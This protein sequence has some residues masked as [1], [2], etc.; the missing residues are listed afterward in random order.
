MHD[1][2]QQ[3]FSELDKFQKLTD[4]ARKIILEVAD[5]LNDG[6][7]PEESTTG[8]LFASLKGL[9]K[10]YESICSMIASESNVLEVSQKELSAS[11]LRRIAKGINEA[12]ELAKEDLRRFIRIKS[13][14]EMFSDQIKPVQEKAEKLLQR[15]EQNPTGSARK[16]ALNEA[17]K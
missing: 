3:I 2:Q 17:V 9:R 12:A 6:Y 4:D 15:L 1:I 16:S 7:S 11:E 8:N 14:M 13:S 5:K 10:L